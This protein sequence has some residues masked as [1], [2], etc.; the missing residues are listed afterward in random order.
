MAGYVKVMST[1]KAL[2][3]YPQKDP[4]RNP[5]N[6]DE[7][8]F[9]SGAIAEKLG[10]AGKL[11]AKTYEQILEGEINGV[12]LRDKSKNTEFLKDKKGEYVL[13]EDGNKIKVDRKAIEYVFTMDK[14][15]SIMAT[16][17][18]RIIDA[19]DKS[20]R[21]TK[22]NLLEAQFAQAREYES[23]GVR[24]KKSTGALLIAEARHGVSRPTADAKPDMNFHSHI[25]I[26]NTT[27]NSKGKFVSL[28]TDALIDNQE[29]TNK[30]QKEVFANELKSLGYALSYD[31]KGNFKIAGVSDDL[32]EH[33]SKRSNEITKQVEALRENPKFAGKSEKEL[34]EY[35]QLN[36]KQEKDDSTKEDLYK[37]WDRQFKEETITSKEEMLASVKAESE[38]QRTKEKFSVEKVLEVASKNLMENESYVDKET[39]IKEALK[40]NQGDN[41]VEDIEKSINSIKK[42]GQTNPFDLKKITVDGKDFYTNKEMYDIQKENQQMIL[43]MS[44]AGTKESIMSKEEASEQIKAFEE[45]E[46]FQLSQGQRDMFSLVLT[47]DKQLT[48]TEGKAGAGK[49]TVAKGIRESVEATGQDAKKIL[50][51]LG[52]TGKA[53][54]GLQDESGIQSNTVHS[55]LIKSSKGDLSESELKKSAKE[56]N[57]KI[58]TASQAE[59]NEDLTSDFKASKIKKEE[60]NEEEKSLDSSK[61]ESKKEKSDKSID[62]NSEKK[63]SSDKESS[64]EKNKK[65]NS[66]SEHVSTSKEESKNKSSKE[67]KNKNRFS[68]TV[69]V[70]LNTKK[71]KN[72]ANSMS[73]NKKEEGW[74][75]KGL[76]LVVKHD[77]LKLKGGGGKF[78]LTKLEEGFRSKKTTFNKE[79]GMVETNSKTKFGTRKSEFGEHHNEHKMQITDIYKDGAKREIE[80]S[81]TNMLGK[82]SSKKDKKA[83]KIAGKD[84][85][86]DTLSKKASDM[87]YKNDSFR[88]K[89]QSATNK[90]SEFEKKDASLFAGA[91]G[92]SKEE[93]KHVFD[94]KHHFKEKESTF[95]GFG[96]EFNSKTQ[97]KKGNLG[98]EAFGKSRINKEGRTLE[99]KREANLKIFGKDI[100]VS[101]L[102]KDYSKEELTFDN[103]KS[104]MNSFVESLKDRL[105]NEK[106]RDNS[107]VI[108]EKEFDKNGNFQ[109]GSVTSTKEVEYKKES[110]TQ[111]NRTEVSNKKAT[112]TISLE[113][114]GQSVDVKEQKVHKKEIGEKDLDKIAKEVK[115]DVAEKEKSNESTKEESVKKTEIAGKKMWLLDEAGMLDARAFNSLLKEAKKEGASIH[116]VGDTNQIKAVGAGDTYSQIVKHAETAHITE[117]KR[118]KDEDYKKSVQMFENGNEKDAMEKF[119]K[120]GKFK[121]MSK[122]EIIDKM[123]SNIKEDKDILTTAKRRDTVKEINEQSREKIFGSKDFGVKAEIN[124]AI[125]IQ[126]D[127]K[128]K[129]DN[130]EKG[131]TLGLKFTTD[132]G[133]QRFSSYEV[134]EVNKDRNQLTLGSDKKSS[135]I[136]DLRTESSQ[137]STATRKETVSFAVGDKVI[138]TKNDKK[139][140]GVL[141]GEMGTIK[142]IDEKN[143]TFIAEM[144]AD[145]RDIEYSYGDKKGLDIAH[146]FSITAN[147]SQGMTVD[148]VQSANFNE[149]RSMVNRNINYV[150][151]TRGRQEALTFAENKNDMLDKIELEQEKKSLTDSS[152]L[153]AEMSDFEKKLEA[154]KEENNK[155]DVFKSENSNKD[156]FSS[157]KVESK[158]SFDK[159]DFKEVSEKQ[160]TKE[161]PVREAKSESKEESKESNKEVK[162]EKTEKQ[163]EEVISR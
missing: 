12:K 117:S 154:K 45:R 135:F 151:L 156:V 106:N 92:N 155:P 95:K 146:G 63:V 91:L 19:F 64:S 71:V 2:E 11:S 34:R 68:P 94:G 147:K 67:D 104:K 132:S 53:S 115:K 32:I 48:A 87:L 128:S 126:G 136:L 27:I 122:S 22:E 109:K 160:E 120:D 21:L 85:Y 159:T 150:E 108:V 23:D 10:I 81:K 138:H 110:Y 121:E 118:Q 158:S 58:Q 72:H 59:I 29:L 131:D 143:K 44:K 37:D 100:D 99:F 133:K 46:G 51:G 17:D 62:V 8:F 153:K 93:N 49:T 18:S 77:Y 124:V 26:M 163:Q 13:D 86:K 82:S 141:N 16:Q 50:N 96:V 56:L 101:F 30:Y 39:L 88:Y 15:S 142:S 76:P 55:F 6:T 25:Y 127:L 114:E 161:E 84:V 98:F 119:E 33:F 52:S 1:K 60:V 89:Q 102:N 129:A 40:V 78:E 125:D 7:N 14:A 47:T 5:N 105:E 36:Y 145:K 149:D 134:K 130:F 73:E 157:D 42:T 3:Y 144:G 70:A 35:A 31:S 4:I 140:L 123:T 28:N 103:L 41:R 107:F 24:R 116:A 61:S 75:T 80:I 57:S 97:E 9:V 43:E 162:T 69:E 137:I 113:K 90:F 112:T 83:S 79:T 66:N 139:D 111:V 148:R 38:Y 20:V 54:S 152:E 65:V 74:F